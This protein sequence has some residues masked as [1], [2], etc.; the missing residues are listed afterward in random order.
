MLI[1]SSVLFEASGLSGQTI[2][3]NISKA[4]DGTITAMILTSVP[5]VLLDPS[6]GTH[7]IASPRKCTRIVLAAALKFRHGAH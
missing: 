6:T 3:Y 7:D 1:G 5:T 2:I 4:R